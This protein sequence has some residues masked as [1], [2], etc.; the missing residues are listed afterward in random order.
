MPG[1]TPLGGRQRLEY[2]EKHALSSH[3]AAPA[4]RL[5]RF[6]FGN[7]R[8][9][10]SLARPCTHFVHDCLG[11]QVRQPMLLACCLLAWFVFAREGF[12]YMSQ[13]LYGYWFCFFKMWSYVVQAGLELSV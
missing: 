13:E 4:S 11:E 12:Q 8:T 9:P 1:N 3:S 2:L 10:L 5:L 7:G 6:L